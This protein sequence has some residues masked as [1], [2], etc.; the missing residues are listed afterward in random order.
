MLQLTRGLLLHLSHDSVSTMSI[1]SIFLAVLA[2]LG[3]CSAL[4]SASVRSMGKC[5]SSALKKT[6]FVS[7]R[8]AGPRSTQEV[9][10]TGAVQNGKGMF[11][12]LGLF[13]ASRQ[14]ASASVNFDG[15][16]YGDKELKVATLNKLK[17]TLRNSMNK[18]P[19]LALAYFQ[20]AV[21]DALG[22]D[23]SSGD[24][25]L[26][27]SIAFEN[28]PISLVGAVKALRGVQEEL[29]ATNAISFAD[30]LA[31]GGAEAL[32]TVGAA[33]IT[34]Q[35][36][37]ADAKKAN[38]KPPSFDIW[39]D[40]SE[41]PISKAKEV[42]ISAGLNAKEIA[43]LLCAH[44]EM[45]NILTPILAKANAAKT[46]VDSEDDEEDSEDDED[47]DFV[48]S[49]F[50]RR[51]MI[52]GAKL[53][54]SFSN[55][56]VKDLLAAVKKTAPSEIRLSLLDRLLLEDDE[57]KAVAA[58]FASSDKA[59]GEAIVQAYTKLCGL[60]LTGSRRTD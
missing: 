43:A 51:D 20:L 59:F 6:M 57:V 39:G 24:G 26:D 36:G 21:S 37:R 46:E 38:A 2:L 33:R 8:E 15:D 55:S 17:Q 13:L 11:A 7:R 22:F 54:S 1:S 16:A 14:H 58:S 28:A 35:L 47:K 30:V 60:G 41:A 32:E 23:V 18:S 27:G 31:F 56:Y 34:V 53:S 52:Y 25:G 3:L 44:G 48:P 50:G 10:R 4:L 29:T 42:F 19:E 49:S 5:T 45:K 40:S 12:I 9:E